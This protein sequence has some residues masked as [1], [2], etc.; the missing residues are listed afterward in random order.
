MES[1]IENKQYPDIDAF[2]SDLALI[3]NNAMVYNADGT[4]YFKVC[5]CFRPRFVEETERACV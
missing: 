4:V 2:E 3:C 1:K 5:V